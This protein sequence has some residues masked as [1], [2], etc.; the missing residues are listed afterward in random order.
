[1]GSTIFFIVG[2]FSGGTG[3]EDCAPTVFSVV[4]SWLG[5]F[6]CGGFAVFS[7]MLWWL[8]GFSDVLSWLGGFFCGAAVFFCAFDDACFAAIGFFCFFGGDSGLMSISWLE[9][10]NG[11]CVDGERGDIEGREDDLGD[12]DGHDCGGSVGD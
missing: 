12:D 6:F 3:L 5:G 9:L 1:M 10:N 2:G 7:D 4:L 8:G 11:S